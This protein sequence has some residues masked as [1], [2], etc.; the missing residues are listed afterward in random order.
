VHLAYRVLGDGEIPLVFMPG[1]I[2]NVD[3]Y[4]DPGFPFGPLVEQLAQQTRL[5]LWDKRGTG[6]SDPVTRVP[7]LD[8]RMEDLC[9]VLTAADVED[10]IALLG[11]SEGGP[12]SI[13]F[14]ATFPERVRSLVLY[15]TAA[16]FAVELPDFP[17]GQSPEWVEQTIAGID[18]H[19]GEGTIADKLFNKAA[20]IPGVR[21]MLGRYERASASPAMGAMIFR[22]IPKSTSGR[23]CTPYRHVHWSWPGPPIAWCPSRLL[24]LWPQHCPMPSSGPCRRGLMR[25]W[26]VRWR[27]KH[28]N[29]SAGQQTCP[30]VNVC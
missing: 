17:W 4:D 15:G 6:L 2:S 14:A 8:E 20:D 9:A 21:E 16:R 12:L 22:A 13:L 23:Y 5:I 11:I 28:S 10:P 3:L 19:W 24:R 26:I 7:T 29:S 25:P 30:A 1:Y 27:P 18:D